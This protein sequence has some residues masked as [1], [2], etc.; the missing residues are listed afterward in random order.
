MAAL[1]HM[2][3]PSVAAH[4][5]PKEVPAIYYTYKGWRKLRKLMSIAAAKAEH[6]SSFFKGNVKTSLLTAYDHA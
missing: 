2:H 6:E 1:L 5:L 3:F 4:G